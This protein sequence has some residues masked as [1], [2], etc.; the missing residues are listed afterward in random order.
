MG[1]K[2]LLSDPIYLNKM[3]FVANYNDLVPQP[4]TE[5]D[6]VSKLKKK[7]EYN[8]ALSMWI[9]INPHRQIQIALI[10]SLLLCLIT[11]GNHKFFI[12][13]QQIH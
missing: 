10:P 3:N 5:D 8:Y 9:Y 2:Q 4:K 13:R 11:V 7:Y 12:K 6:H 1:G